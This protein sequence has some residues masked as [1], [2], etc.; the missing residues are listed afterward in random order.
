M[1]TKNCPICNKEVVAYTEKQADR[2]IANHK[3]WK[4]GVI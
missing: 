4:H 1:I 2:M 3:V